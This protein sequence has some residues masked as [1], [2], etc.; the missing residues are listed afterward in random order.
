VLVDGVPVQY[1]TLPVSPDNHYIARP[2]ARALE[3]TR[4][5]FALPGAGQWHTDGGSHDCVGP[6]HNIVPRGR[7][8]SWSGPS[9]DTT[10]QATGNVGLAE[11]GLMVSGVLAACVGKFNFI[12]GCTKENF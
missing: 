6:V 1:N 10:R 5:G 2:V 12:E 8:Q 11:E 4:N 7:R 9:R 3:L